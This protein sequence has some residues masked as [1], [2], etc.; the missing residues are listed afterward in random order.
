[1]IVLSGSA[2]DGL[3]RIQEGHGAGKAHP[4][5]QIQ[6]AQAAGDSQ[7]AANVA[8]CGGGVMAG[9]WIKMRPSLLT[10]P[11]VNGI[12]RL[13]ESDREVSGALSTGYAGDMNEIVTRNVMRHVTVSSLLIIWGAANEHTDNGV[14]KNADLSDISDMV[15]IPGFGE[16]MESV[17]WAK[18]DPEDNTVTLPNFNEYNTS[19]ASRSAGAKT[20]AQRQKEYRDRKKQQ[21]SCVTSDVTSDVTSNRRE[22]KRR[23]IDAPQAAGDQSPSA[24][25]APENQESYFGGNGEDQPNSRK[26]GTRLPED[27]V[28]PKAW[29]EW[30][31][32]ERK[33][34]IADDVR[35]CAEKFADYWRAKAGRDAAKLDWQATWRNWVRNDN[36]S[37]SRPSH[38]NGSGS[39]IFAGMI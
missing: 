18:Y 3:A 6:A 29:G 2:C 13:L 15:G 4:G 25:A 39:S 35:R 19:G 11:K 5:D 1:M 36:T 23:Y 7:P 31:L 21:N 20:S 34:W 33:G 38:P 14:F 32:A 22:E 28:L 24:P 16:A 37:A 10:S 9:D 12:A 26:R 30:A 17:G 8:Q 27:W